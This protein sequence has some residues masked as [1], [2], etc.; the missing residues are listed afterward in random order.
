MVTNE[1][2]CQKENEDENMAYTYMYRPNI[3]CCYNTHD[4][5]IV[6]SYDVTDWVIVGL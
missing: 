5:N 3:F 4:T 6:N 1:L 2:Q